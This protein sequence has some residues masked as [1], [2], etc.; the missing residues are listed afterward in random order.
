MDAPLWLQNLIIA[1]LL[2]GF[3]FLLYSVQYG[4]F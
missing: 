2:A 1:C 3:L 4:L